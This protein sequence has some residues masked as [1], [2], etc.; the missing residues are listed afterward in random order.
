MG[1]LTDFV[2]PLTR[3]KFGSKLANS[4]RSSTP[5]HTQT[6]FYEITLFLA[7]VAKKVDA[8]ADEVEQLKQ[9][10]AAG[11]E[12]DWTVKELRVELDKLGVP[13]AHCRLK[14]DYLELYN[15]AVAGNTEPE[16]PTEE[17]V[18]EDT[19]S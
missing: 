7:T 6:P 14:H 18:T 12:R 11:V 5:Y 13:H 8:L 1:K 17:T 16:G 3:Q 2:V 9:I 19:T 4:Y 10:V 15:R